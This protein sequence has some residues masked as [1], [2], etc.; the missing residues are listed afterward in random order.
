MKLTEVKYAVGPTQIFV[1]EAVGSY[2]NIGPFS[3]EEEAKKFIETAS[4]L[5]PNELRSLEIVET[6]S[7]QEYL[8][9]LMA[10]AK[11]KADRLRR[12]GKKKLVRRKIPKKVRSLRQS[13]QRRR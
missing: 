6:Q 2:A 13:R 3:S 9:G 11:E 5:D 10:E 7:P 4:S 8:E 1:K 12:R